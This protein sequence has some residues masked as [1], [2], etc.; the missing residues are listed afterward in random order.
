MANVSIILE[1]ETRASN[2]ELHQIELDRTDSFQFNTTDS[3]YTSD[4]AANWTAGPTAYQGATFATAVYNYYTAE[5]GVANVASVDVLYKLW[6][7]GDSTGGGTETAD[8]VLALPTS[9]SEINTQLEGLINQ[10]IVKAQPSD[11]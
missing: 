6:I 3:T 11:A 4:L 5:L 8:G 1:V 9:A 7:G 2:P 10:I